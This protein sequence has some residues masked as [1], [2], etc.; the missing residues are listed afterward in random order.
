MA[1]TVSREQVALGDR[2]YDVCLANDFAGIGAALQRALPGT[3]RVVVVTDDTVEPLWCDALEAAL[4]LPGMR[5]VLP[6]GESNKT[7]QT[8][9]QCVDAILNAGVDRRTPV[10]A[11]GGGVV[12]DIAGFAAASALRG[13]P[14]VQVPT[15]VLAMV[16]SSV[17]GKTG[18]NH[19]NGKNLVGAF[20]QPRLVWAALNTL[21]TLDGAER[22]A[23][24]GEVLKTGL[25]TGGELWTLLQTHGPLL[26]TG[27]VETTRRAIQLCVRAKADVV[28]KDEREGGIRAILNAG[29]TAGHAVEK[30]LG[31]GKLRHGAAVAL[32]L[33]AE[34]RYAVKIGVCLDAALPEKLL[35]LIDALGLP[36]RTPEVQQDALMKA[37][38][39]DKKAVGDMV[40]VPLLVRVGEVKLVDIGIAGLNDL[41]GELP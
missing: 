32:G 11:L 27:D 9:S 14:F 30:A 23:G 16:D 41:L 40:R 8:W 5:V 3:T 6:A 19:P 34:A 20:Y 2:A 31:Y 18:V 17:G 29:H 28:A 24:L 39:M 13:L 37:V 21:S 15:T 12:G 38:V 7:V 22:R 36:S 26:G 10:V 35:E 33:V 1:N 4:K 25:L